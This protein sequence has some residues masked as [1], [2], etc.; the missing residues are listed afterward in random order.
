MGG[1]RNDGCL[2]GLLKLGALTWVHDWLQGRAGFGK[3]C[4]C[5]GIGCG[6]ILLVAFLLM[7]CGIVFDTNWFRLLTVL[8]PLP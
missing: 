8:V 6:L 2:P 1:N 5:S 3:G 4:S 7:A